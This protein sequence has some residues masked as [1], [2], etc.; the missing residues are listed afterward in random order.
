MKYLR[1]IGESAGS[2]T[3]NLPIRPPAPHPRRA[4]RAPL[5]SRVG[6][7]PAPTPSRSTLCA[8]ERLKTPW[9]SRGDELE[10]LPASEPRRCKRVREY[11]SGCRRG[12]WV[13]L[14]DNFGDCSKAG[15]GSHT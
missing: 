1:K 4:R 3:S 11:P 9:K 10:S 14:E 6:R 7:D 2:A 5:P 8:V 15:F 12:R 13:I